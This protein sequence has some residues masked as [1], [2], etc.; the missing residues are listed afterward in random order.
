[1]QDPLVMSE[2]ARL[3]REGQLDEIKALL[4]SAGG[5]R[6]RFVGGAVLELTAIIAFC[7]ALSKVTDGVKGVG[8]MVALAKKLVRWVVSLRD[9][10]TETPKPLSLRE[11]AL[12]LLFETKA[13][14]KAG[15]SEAKLK[16]I[17]GCGEAELAEALAVL[18]QA[19]VIRQ[20]AGGGGEYAGG[21][22]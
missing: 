6:A 7:E 19:G 12:V 14:R 9:G 13:T 20:A 11:R 4:P 18:L 5:D 17:L 15:L 16:Q 21:A 8:E 10:A 2:F 22:V 1:M 3:D